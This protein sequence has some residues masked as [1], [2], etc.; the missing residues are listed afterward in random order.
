MN[1]SADVYSNVGVLLHSTSIRAMGALRDGRLVTGQEDGAV[2]IWTIDDY[3][4]AG[5]SLSLVAYS[6]AAHFIEIGTEL[7]L[8]LRRTQNAPATMQFFDP[9]CVDM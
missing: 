4:N 7:V 5:K 2:Q 8:L 1:V 6:S 9:A 3:I